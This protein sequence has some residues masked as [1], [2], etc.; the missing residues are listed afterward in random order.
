MPLSMMRNADDILDRAVLLDPGIEAIQV[1]NPSGIIVHSSSPEKPDPITQLDLLQLRLSNNGKWSVEKE[2]RF[3][4]YLSIFNSE[5]TVVGGVVAT[6]PNQRFTESIEKVAERVFTAVAGFLLIF[7]LLTLVVLRIRLS[8]VIDGAEM[9]RCWLTV[10]KSDQDNLDNPNQL[11]DNFLE[12]HKELER[13]DRQYHD[14]CRKFNV[15]ASPESVLTEVGVERMRPVVMSTAETSLARSIANSLTPWTIGLILLATLSLGIVTYSSLSDSFDPELAKR[16]DLIAQ[17]ANANI[18]RAASAGIPLDGLVGMDDFFDDLLEN[19]PEVSYFGVATGEMIYQA[20]SWKR[21]FLRGNPQN[22]QQAPIYPINLEGDQ[23]GY[24]I[25]DP[26]TEYIALQF[27][28]LMLDMAVVILVVLLLAYEIMIV[29]MS[30]SLTSPLVRLRYLAKLQGSGDFSCVIANRR[31]SIVEE[32]NEILARR[33]RV[34]HRYYLTALESVA[35]TGKELRA[36]TNLT[37]LAK[38]FH[39]GSKSPQILSFSYLNDVRLPL[40]LFAAADELPLSFFPIFTRAAENPITLLEPAVV[41]SLP[42]AGY[43]LAFMLASPYSR[44]LSERWGHRKLLLAALAPV[45]LSNLGMFYANNVVEI[46]LLRTI[47]GAGYA[48]AVLACQDY[49]LDVVPK[50]QRTKSLGLF[51]TALFG[52]IFAGTAVGGIFADRFGHSM[53][54]LVSALLVFIAALLFYGMIPGGRR[55]VAERETKLSWQSIFWAVKDRRCFGIIFGL[56]IPQSVMDQVFISY[57]FAL[58]LDALDAS[59]AV[60]GRMLM[61]YFLMIMLA[62]SLIGW[63]SS[64]KISNQALAILGSLLTGLVLIQTAYM[65]YQWAMLVAAAGAGLGHGLVRGPQVEMAMNLAET[66]LT[67][68]GTDSVLGAL[69]FFERVGSLIGLLI[70]AAITGYFGIPA[71]I[72]VIGVL[73]LFGMVLYGLS[74]S[75]AVVFKSK[76]NYQ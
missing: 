56:A 3:E 31:G 37:D 75:F 50:E 34:L 20:G 18:Q 61:A 73:I 14:A 22:D 8:K 11:N 4:S 32:I 29:I 62:G 69:R 60:I 24:I 19:F 52:G 15:A 64:F 44:A 35:R 49:V 59:A 74:A 41:I 28:E 9:L 54:F 43:L 47:A 55:Q 17:V 51:S 7:S 10:S 46:I 21:S 72:A 6:Y 76:N 53:V 13:A 36:K 12:L 16:T 65:P 70:V 67:D 57:L 40:F 5:G 66:R 1:F 71:A 48:V 42:L 38:N 27:R 58:Q 30:F 39:L 63:L 68:L 25:I 2:G 45:L 26:D 33:A 23:I